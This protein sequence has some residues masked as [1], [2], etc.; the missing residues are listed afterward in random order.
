MALPVALLLSLRY[1]SVAEAVPTVDDLAG[2]WVAAGPEVDMPQISA[3]TSSAGTNP[4][5]LFSIN[6]FLSG[7]FLQGTSLANMTVDGH[8]LK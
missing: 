7:P 4:D 3:F 2:D 1:P 5:D 8:Q 6:S